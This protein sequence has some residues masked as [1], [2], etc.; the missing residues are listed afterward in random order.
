MRLPPVPFRAHSSHICQR[1]GCGVG[2]FYSYSHRFNCER[3]LQ[4][5]TSGDVLRFICFCLSTAYIHPRNPARRSRS[6]LH[7]TRLLLGMKP[8]LIKFLE[9]GRR[10]SLATFDRM[11]PSQL[12]ALSHARDRVHRKIILCAMLL[13]K[14]GAPI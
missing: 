1:R 9:L 2:Q 13:S 5:I 12:L 7:L 6:Q 8:L 4:A 14:A 10:K 3:T 11:P